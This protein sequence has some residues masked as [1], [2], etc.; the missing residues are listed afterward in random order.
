MRILLRLADEAR[1]LVLVEEA[2]LSRVLAV[3][4]VPIRP[5]QDER[6]LGI[7][8]RRVAF[9]KAGA[10]QFT[11]P[12]VQRLDD[13]FFALEVVESRPHL[14]PSAEISDMGASWKP[15]SATTSSIAL[16][17][18]SRLFGFGFACHAFHSSMADA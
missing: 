5:H 14:L 4:V 1:S 13:C 17:M 16:R 8:I 11:D 9:Q 15:R 7:H 2:H 18:A 3:E 12:L 6:F 10:L